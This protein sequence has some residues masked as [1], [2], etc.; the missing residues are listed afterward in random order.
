LKKDAKD[1]I[2]SSGSKQY[3]ISTH[4]DFVT[5]NK[6]ALLKHLDCSVKDLVKKFSKIKKKH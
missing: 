4:P 6:K 5:Y 2:E 3:R 1:F